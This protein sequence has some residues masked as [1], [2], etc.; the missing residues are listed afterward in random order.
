M[1][2]LA[3]QQLVHFFVAQVKTSKSRARV[4]GSPSPMRRLQSALQQAIQS[5][6]YRQKLVHCSFTH[7]IGIVTILSVRS[8][9]HTRDLR[10]GE[11]L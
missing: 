11:N 9:L 10:K 8:R 2:G 6:Q 7:M 5:L 1:A 3:L 4:V